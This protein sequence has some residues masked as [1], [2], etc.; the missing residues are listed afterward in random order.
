MESPDNDSTHATFSLEEMESALEINSGMARNL[1]QDL[2][3]PTS[4]AE[5][6]EFIRYLHELL[7]IKGH[8]V[9]GN[10]IATVRN[11]YHDDLID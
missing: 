10:P 6:Y 4:E 11:S 5:Y 1:K 3:N 7:V 9:S 2:D 8:F